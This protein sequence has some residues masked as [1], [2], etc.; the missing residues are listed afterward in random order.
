MAKTIIGYKAN[1]I[2]G[3]EEVAIEELAEAFWKWDR[4]D[5]ETMLAR[6]VTFW[7]AISEQDGGRNLAVDWGAEENGNG[8]ALDDLLQAV[9][10]ARPGRKE[11]LEKIPN[12][13]DGPGAL[14]EENLDYLGAGGSVE[15]YRG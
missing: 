10:E 4:A 11:R 3:R 1:R 6:K 9:V 7:I 15:A 2:D 13:L 5:E 8:D 12:R 14:A